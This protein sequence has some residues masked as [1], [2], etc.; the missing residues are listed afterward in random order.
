MLKDRDRRLVRDIGEHQTLVSSVRVN[1]VLFGQE[2]RTPASLQKKKFFY[3]HFYLRRYP[4]GHVIVKVVVEVKKFFRS[5]AATRPQNCVTAQSHRNNLGPN[6]NF[7]LENLRILRVFFEFH[8]AFPPRKCL[9]GGGNTGSVKPPHLYYFYRSLVNPPSLGQIRRIYGT[10][11]P[12][13]GKMV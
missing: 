13:P 9:K 6:E 2:N 11:V 10:G 4:S 3:F 1:R 5:V 12:G 8:G 7:P